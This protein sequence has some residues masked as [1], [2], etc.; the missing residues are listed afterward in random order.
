MQREHEIGLLDDLLAVEVEVGEMQQQRI[1]LGLVA[2]KFQ[3][4]CSVNPSA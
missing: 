3:T 2:S 1:L 4:S